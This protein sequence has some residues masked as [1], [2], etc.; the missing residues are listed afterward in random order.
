MKQIIESLEDDKSFIDKY[1]FMEKITDTDL[2]FKE[3]K[4]IFTEPGASISGSEDQMLI[5]QI[6]DLRGRAQ[7]EQIR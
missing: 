5:F 7:Q 4:R 3:Y 6:F 2:V 1:K